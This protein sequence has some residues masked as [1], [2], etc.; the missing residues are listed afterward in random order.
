MAM[1]CCEADIAFHAFM[2]DFRDVKAEGDDGWFIVTAKMEYK[3]HRAYGRKGPVL[4]ATEIEPCEAPD[5]S[6]A[7]FF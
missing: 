5:P 4:T 6:V 3:F 1:T 2:C 7:T